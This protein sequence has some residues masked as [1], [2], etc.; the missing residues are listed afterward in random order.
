MMCIHPQCP[1]SP[2][3]RFQ[4]HLVLEILPPFRIILYWTTLAKIARNSNHYLALAALLLL[5]PTQALAQ[6]IVPADEQAP[7]PGAAGVAPLRRLEIHRHLHTGNPPGTA[8]ASR[9]TSGRGI[10]DVLRGPLEARRRERQV[11]T[12][13]LS[14][15]GTKVELTNN[16]KLT[17]HYQCTYPCGDER[18]SKYVGWFRRLCK[19]HRSR[20]SSPPVRSASLEIRHEN[21]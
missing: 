21:R 5:V 6:V 4:D 20:N 18:S 17:R 1:S 2:L 15:G 19:F 16:P 9:S 14:P 3:G 7:L 11:G 12:F 13:F 10:S 8:G